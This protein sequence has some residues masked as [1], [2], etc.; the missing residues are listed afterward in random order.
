MTEGTTGDEAPIVV[1]ADWLVENA[2][3]IRV[4]DVREAWEYEGIGHVPGAV[5]IPFDSFR[6]GGSGAG[7]VSGEGG[8]PGSEDEGMLPGAD[9]FGRLMGEAG[10]A[11]G[12]TVVAYDD[13]HGVFAARFVVTALLYGHGDVHLLDGDFSAWSRDHETTTEVPDVEPVDYEATVPADRP[14][15]DAE[16]VLAAVDD[17][18]AVL[19]DTRTPEEYEAGHIEGAV[20]LDWRELVDPDT[21]GF[22]PREELEAVLADHGVVPEKRVVLYCNTA[23]RISHTYVALRHLGFP[24][25]DFYEGSLTD[26]EARGLDLVGEG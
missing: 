15:I 3:E 14:L 19:V 11:P 12:D 13:E 23:R 7:D 24:E 6:A 10:I 17:P 16:A 20:Q 26:W 8:S 2:G 21:R 5:S 22:L 18:D 1:D 9:V 4:V 25:V